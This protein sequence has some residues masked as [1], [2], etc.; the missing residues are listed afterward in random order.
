MELITWSTIYV[1][2]LS[3]HPPGSMIYIGYEDLL[4]HGSIR[5]ERHRTIYRSLT[6]I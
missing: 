5:P 4:G 2:D 3:N 6:G 1:L